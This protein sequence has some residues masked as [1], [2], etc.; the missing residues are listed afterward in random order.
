MLLRNKKTQIF[1]LCVMSAS[2]KL[3][4]KMVR[5]ALDCKQLDLATEEQVY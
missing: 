2:K 3:S 1:I 4:W 5:K